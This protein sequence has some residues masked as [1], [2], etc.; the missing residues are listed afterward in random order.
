MVRKLS[1]ALGAML[2]LTGCQAQTPQAGSVVTT[3]QA[4]PQGAL[5]KL[6]AL[7]LADL[8][9]AIA[10]ANG[11]QPPDTEAV[12]C[13]GFLATNLEA[14]KVGSA[15]ASPIGAISVFEIGHLAVGVA[16]NGLSPG[17]QS[18]LEMACGP[19]ALNTL[20]GIN[21]LLGHL[22]VSAVDLAK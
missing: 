2:A 3:T 10:I 19:L 22:G 5:A 11:A 9:S 18:G 17:L 7:T 4:A 8:Q 6:Q 16:R 12:Q 15:P 20:G 1:I 21:W 14:I 13:Y